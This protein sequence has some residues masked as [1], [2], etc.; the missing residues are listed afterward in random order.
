MKSRI[1][2]YGRVLIPKEVRGKLKIGEGDIVDIS[3]KGDGLILRRK[4]VDLDRRVLEWAEAVLK[5]APKPFMVEVKVGDS[6]WL[7]KGYCLEKLGL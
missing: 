4:D 3:V 1:D 7:S 6:K 5:M 2:K